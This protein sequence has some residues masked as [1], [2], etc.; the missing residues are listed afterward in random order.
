[1][2]SDTGALVVRS[3]GSEIGCVGREFVL[4]IVRLWVEDL[5]PVLAMDAVRSV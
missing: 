2:T 3:G 4:V 5:I 1:M